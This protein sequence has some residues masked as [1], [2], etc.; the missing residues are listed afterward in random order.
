MHKRHLSDLT[1]PRAVL[2]AVAEF[3]RLGRDAF[4]AKYT[5]GEARRYF[6]SHGARHYDSKAIVAAAYGFQYPEH[7]PLVNNEFT[8]GRRT[9]QAKLEELGFT[10][11]VLPP[12]GEQGSDR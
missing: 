10:M 12:V 2:E 6:L 8:G 9:V 4:L 11:V 3:D 7:G 1:S 5:Y